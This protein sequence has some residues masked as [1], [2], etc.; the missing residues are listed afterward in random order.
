MNSPITIGILKN[1]KTKFKNKLFIPSF[2]SLLN[3][4]LGELDLASNEMF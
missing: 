3:C 1:I 4:L 2:I